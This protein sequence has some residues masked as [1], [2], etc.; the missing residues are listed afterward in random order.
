MPQL[1]EAMGKYKS[2]G[3]IIY[4]PYGLIFAPID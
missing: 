4:K 1:A 3:L 2:V